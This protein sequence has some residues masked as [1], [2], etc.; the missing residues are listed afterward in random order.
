[1]NIK[2]TNSSLFKEKREGSK[3]PTFPIYKALREKSRTEIGM[4][5]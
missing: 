4:V 2:L 3:L 1:M 5:P